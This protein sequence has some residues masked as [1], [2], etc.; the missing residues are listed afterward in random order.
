MFAQPGMMQGPVPNLQP[1]GRLNA[2]VIVTRVSHVKSTQ[3]W[4][5]HAYGQQALAECSRTSMASRRYGV[6]DPLIDCQGFSPVLDPWNEWL[7]QRSFSVDLRF[8]FSQ[9]TLA[10][11]RGLRFWLTLA[12][13]QYAPIH[14][15]HRSRVTETAIGRY[16]ANGQNTTFFSEGLSSRHA[17]DGVYGPHI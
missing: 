9:I 6:V 10:Q 11:E 1:K 16:I 15:G 2:P 8:V 13:E 3:R 7:T 5:G 12:S 4:K 17:V 14:A